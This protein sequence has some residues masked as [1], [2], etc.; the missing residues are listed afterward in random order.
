MTER[1]Q[2]TPAEGVASPS[3]NELLN[4]VTDHLATDVGHAPA[5]A[6]P[7]QKYDALSHA[8][9]D[10]LMRSW[11]TTQQRI[12][13][14]QAKRVYYLS[15]EFLIG[16]SL[17]NGALNLEMDAAA[18]GTAHALGQ[19]LEDLEELER[20]AGLGNGG[21]G[22]LAACYLDSMATL[23]IPGFGYGIRFDYG[24]FTQTIDAEG[25]QQEQPSDWLRYGSPWEVSRPELR[26]RIPFGGRCE[27]VSGEGRKPAHRWVET[28]EVEAVAHDIPIPGKFGKVVNHLRLWSAQALAPFD[29]QRFN[30]GDHLGAVSG[31]VAA[32]NL[33]RVLYPDDSTRAGV[34]LRFEQ[35]YFF[36]CASLQDILR[37]HLQAGFAIQE[38]PQRVAIQLNDTH[39][40]LAIPE[41]MRLLL[42]DHG[43]QWNAAWELTQQ[44]F[45][46]TNH[47]LLPEALEV[48]PVS[49]F[50]TLL[51][52]H[53][54][55]IYQINRLLLDQVAT[56]FPQDHERRRHMSLIEED[57][58][59][60]VRMAHLAVVGSHTVNGVAELHSRLMTETI[61]AD[62][63][64]L[65]PEKFTNVTNG[66]TPRR[67]LRQANPAL[68]RLI[69]KRIGPGWEVDLEQLRQLEAAAEDHEFRRR[70]AAAKR[71]NKVRLVELVARQTGVQLRPDALFDVQ[72]KRMH[73]YKRQLLN[74]LYVVHRYNLIRSGQLDQAVPRAVLF[75]G[76]AAPGYFAA[77]QIIKLINGVAR[78]I[79]ADETV[80]DLLKVVF[81]PNYNVS[82]AEAIIPAA[83]LSQQISTAGMEASGTG[84]MK[85]GLN[86][87]LTLG[88][89]DGA[90]I[91][92]REQVGAENMFIFGMNAEEVLER[93]RGGY[94]PQAIAR[95]NAGLQQVLTMISDGY[96]SP[97]NLDEFNNVVDTLLNEGERF[98]VLADFESYVAA[99]ERVDALYKQ[100]EE[101]TRRA[102]L[103]T[104]RL[105]R[106]SSDRSVSEYAEKI[107][108]VSSL[109]DADLVGP[110]SA[111]G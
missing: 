81:L 25:A 78:V 21:L 34:E 12:A 1:L 48:W 52:R 100:P 46:Y 22:R 92:M 47:T 94:D 63:F 83:D 75:S 20:D 32:K 110:Q 45:S 74:L 30:R 67:W 60:K 64:A 9:R 16:R 101:W 59:K 33:S 10:Q 97:G 36:V 31:Q 50:E 109:L 11:L 91:E 38:L 102:I 89:L 29:L 79:N 37:E 88:T 24:I 86:G 65:T 93:W 108:N 5:Q 82:L 17:G 68:A 39:P 19:E 7:R 76:K 66:V 53:L 18:R 51:P 69:T 35:Q 105:G 80:G 90:N 61:F 103:N 43:M 87:A 111:S 8:I 96:F 84:N 6:S 4:R 77:K 49:L 14:Q 98:L 44:V 55:I 3:V 95:D 72:I 57:H 85:L 2:A 26:Y 27:S 42:D 41:L 15:M 62:F 99:Q 40:A 73:E 71:D 107:W 28:R 56:R 70:F 58:G 23:G 106:F 54:H 104:A 13:A